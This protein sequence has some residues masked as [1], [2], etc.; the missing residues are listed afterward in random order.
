VALLFLFERTAMLKALDDVD[1]SN[2]AERF[3]AV[4]AHPDK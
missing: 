4:V 3:R 2:Y 1:A